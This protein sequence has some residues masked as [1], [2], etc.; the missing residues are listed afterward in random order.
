[1]QVLVRQAAHAFQQRPRAHRRWI[2][3]FHPLGG[4]MERRQEPFPRRR[5][6]MEVKRAPKDAWDENQQGEQKRRLGAEGPIVLRP[7]GAGENLA[8]REPLK[9]SPRKIAGC[10]YTL[11]RNKE[12]M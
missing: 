5:V 7:D 4:L 11:L 1:M 9:Y 6:G 8:L 12:L 10:W 3:Q 2:L